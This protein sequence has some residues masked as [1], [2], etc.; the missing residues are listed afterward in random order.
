MSKLYK[1]QE[2]K[3]AKDKVEQGLLDDLELHKN[4]LVLH[5]FEVV[6]LIGV[7]TDN[8]DYYW[9]IKHC[10]SQ[11]GVEYISCVSGFIPLKGKLLDSDY[12]HMEMCWKLN[13][14]N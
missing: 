13:T 2:L 8:E 7:F 3:K 14:S 5:I 9:K 4:E 12:R 10:D 1:M 6:Q 11:D